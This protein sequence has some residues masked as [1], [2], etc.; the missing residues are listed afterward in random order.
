MPGAELAVLA[1]CHTA[2]TS[3]G[4]PEESLHRAGAMQF[5]GLR[6]VVGSLWEID[7]EDGSFVVQERYRR[8]FETS[9]ETERETTD[10]YA[11]DEN[12]SL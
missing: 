4:A 5:A 11:C 2:G 1:D 9:Q 12:P 3:S 6:S 10:L 7:D 8:L